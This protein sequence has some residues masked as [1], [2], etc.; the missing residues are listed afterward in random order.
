V[1]APARTLSV[2]VLGLLL[3]LTGV[4]CAGGHESRTGPG[5]SSLIVLDRSI[6]GVALK[7]ERADV[8]RRLGR[9]R[10]VQSRDQKP[11]EP[12]AHSEHVRYPMDG[13]DVWYVSRDATS[14]ERERARVFAVRTSSTRYRTR[15]GV[16][17]GSPV[18]MLRALRGLE[19][20][21]ESC[22]HGFHGARRAGTAFRLDRPGG[23][24]TWIAVS[25]GGD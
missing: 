8:E 21:A 14:S 10:L 13:L 2:S 16:R 4:A 17:V 25:V 5:P 9:G 23:R 24:V 1:S 12:P 15:G 7:E 6:G 18:G 3:S 19:C 20:F 11:P 22:Q